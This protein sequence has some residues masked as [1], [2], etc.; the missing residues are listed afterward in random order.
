[1]IEKDSLKNLFGYF[2]DGRKIGNWMV[3]G[4]VLYRARFFLEVV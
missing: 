2:G 4:E 3:V 1:M